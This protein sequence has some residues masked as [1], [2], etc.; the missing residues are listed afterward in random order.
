MNQ[1]KRLKPFIWSNKLAAA[2]RDH[3]KDIGP[4]GLSTSRGSDGS[5]PWDRIERYGK[6]EGQVAENI[7]FGISTGPEYIFT[8]YIDD[9]VPNRKNR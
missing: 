7:A 9:G 5:Q 8:L 4:K 1:Q 6:W 2:A 3:C